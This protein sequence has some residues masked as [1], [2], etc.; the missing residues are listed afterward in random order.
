MQIRTSLVASIATSIVLAAVAAPSALR[1][2]RITLRAPIKTALRQTRS[3]DCPPKQLLTL[4]DSARHLPFVTLGCSGAACDGSG[5]PVAS[6]EPPAGVV[7]SSPTAI[8]APDAQGTGPIAVAA[9]DTAGG[10]TVV[11]CRD[12]LSAK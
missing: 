3:A 11:A 7:A 4:E 1:A 6:Q 5:G 8:G 2:T 12:S 10:P 9:K